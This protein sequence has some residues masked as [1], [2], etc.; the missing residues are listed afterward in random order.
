MQKKVM[1]TLDIVFMPK[2]IASQLAIALAL[3]TSMVC[4]E[5]FLRLRGLFNK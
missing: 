2:Q 5:S 1:D 4:R 3:E